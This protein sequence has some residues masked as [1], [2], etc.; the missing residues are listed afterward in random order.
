MDEPR[1]RNI[2]HF[3]EKVLRACHHEF[4]CLTQEDAAVKLGVSA[5]KISRALNDMEKRSKTCTP[6]AIMFPILTKR[7][8]EVYNCLMKHGLSALETATELGTTE[9]AVNK[10]VHA[11]RDKGMKIPKR[12]GQPRTT[13]YEPSMDK[14]VKYKF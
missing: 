7:Q 6:I 2:T 12:S 3:E 9:S 10:A 11:I 1:E 5:A 8:F 4:D 13:T 14:D